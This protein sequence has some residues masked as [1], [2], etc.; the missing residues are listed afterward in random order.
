M[1]HGHGL[2]SPSLKVKFAESNSGRVE[3]STS[4][5]PERDT[6]PCSIGSRVLRSKRAVECARCPL[7]VFGVG[8]A[9]VPGHRLAIDGKLDGEIFRCE[10]AIA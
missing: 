4:A 2:F 1:T 7:Q 3:S 9:R 10:L 5:Q 6:S 8:F